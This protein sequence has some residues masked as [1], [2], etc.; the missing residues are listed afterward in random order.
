[1]ERTLALSWILAAREVNPDARLGK[2]AEES[3]GGEVFNLF[4][5]G[6][7]E[8]VDIC[9]SVAHHRFLGEPHGRLWIPHEEPNGSC[10]GA[11]GRTPRRFG[12]VVLAGSPQ[13][14][15]L[16]AGLPK[17]TPGRK[18]H[19]KERQPCAREFVAR[20]GANEHD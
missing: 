8:G 2:R 12:R 20:H 9:D 13:E 16:D 18:T 15:Y 10:R 17:E 7:V 11:H 19:P 3:K 5:R 1:M 4:S 14:L 6:L